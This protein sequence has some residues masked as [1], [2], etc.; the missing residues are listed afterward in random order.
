ME[1]TVI[2]SIT[3]PA[4]VVIIILL[5]AIPF[6][7]QPVHI[8]D[9]V[10]ITGAEQF[11]HQ[12][13]N[14][15]AGT[16]GFFGKEVPFYL[17]THP[18]FLFLYISLI[19]VITGQLSVLILH[20][21]YLP[22]S[23][24]AGIC[25]F[26]LAK[27]FS[28]MY[29][30]ITLL[31]LF[32][33][34]FM[35]ISHGLMSDLPM[36][37]L[38]LAALAA[39]IY[40]LDGNKRGLLALSSV[41][42]ALTVLCSYQGLFLLFL[43]YLYTLL[44]RSRKKTFILVS[45][46][47]LCLL[48]A[49][50]LYVRQ[51]T[52]K[53]HIS[54]ALYWTGHNYLF[55]SARIVDC[56]TGSICSLGGVTI[57]PLSLFFLPWKFRKRTGLY[58]I[59]IVV[60]I[61]FL[62]SR[63]AGYLPESKLAF[64]IFFLAGFLITSR[65][66]VNTVTILKKKGSLLLRLRKRKDEAFLAIWYLSF[67][68]LLIMLLPHGIPRYLLPLSFPLITIGMIGF[69][70]SAG[71]RGPKIF[72]GL[73]LIFTLG[74]G[75]LV[76]RVDYQNAWINARAAE[77]IS[78][79]FREEGVDITFTADLGFRYYLEK[80]GHRYL[81]SN[82]SHLNPGEILVEPGNYLKGAI[83]P[84]L[85]QNLEL[86]ERLEYPVS[87]F[88]TLMS[89][90]D[91]ADFYGQ[92]YGFLPYFPAGNVRVF[93]IYRYVTPA[94]YSNPGASPAGI[95]DKMPRHTFS[96]S[97]SLLDWRINRQKLEQDDRLEI[98]LRW[99]VEDGFNSAFHTYLRLSNR[100]SPLVLI[101]EH[102]EDE[103]GPRDWKEGEIV[104]EQYTI[105]HI[106]KNTYP[107]EYE[108]STGIIPEKRQT[109]QAHLPEIEYE[110]FGIGTIDIDPRIYRSDLTTN[111][112]ERYF[113]EFRRFSGPSVSFTL[114]GDKEVIIPVASPNQVSSI[115]IISFL[116][117]ASTLEEGETIALVTVVD[118]TGKCHDLYLKAGEDTADW[119]LGHPGYD[120]SIYQHG[121]AEV[122]NKWRMNYS[123]SLGWGNKYIT[124][125]RLATPITPVKV[126][127]KYVNNTGVWIVDDLALV[128]TVL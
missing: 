127:I 55:S 33:P 48:L 107:G 113:P 19:K 74:T 106:S 15:L 68:A 78:E 91:R 116:A 59:S 122:Y 125:L 25:F 105:A 6:I 97:L 38:F 9:W 54:A 109:R 24:L 95:P 65:I 58:L 111:R 53:F 94:R 8:D 120:R 119:A 10:F 18:P 60:T 66:I 93:N 42:S 112:E 123:G 51:V 21:C 57:F 2:K 87:P 96:S 12:P 63:A 71:R 26:L 46:L 128:E 61:Y 67:L 4:A 75:I 86:V 101:H 77:D 22:F 110:S 104:E 36:L 49:W 20:I 126:M 44:N 121:K 28:R 88:L 47:P 17:V 39:Y 56:F 118:N 41:L 5:L 27:R 43:L 52:G 103:I 73:T 72:L 50:L 30:Y 35:V 92:Y 81:L 90:A 83:S 32:T 64:F 79:R 37:A 102:R 23:L 98:T 80:N 40:G 14:P 7:S 16:I 99:K 34:V 100:Y 117:Y 29:L 114:T 124:Y 85:K 31:F 1:D 62:F 84:E 76:S 70:K 11:C 3:R 108:V 69:E 89:R 45:I 13:L 115:R 82:I